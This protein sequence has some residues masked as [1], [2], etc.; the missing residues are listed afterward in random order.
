MQRHDGITN[1][2]ANPAPAENFKEEIMNL[3]YIEIDDRRYAIDLFNPID[4]ISW[5]S[6]ALAVF[7]SA[8]TK[9]DL[10]VANSDEATK[11]MTE[12]IKR[13]HT[14]KNEPLSDMVVFN[15]HFREHPGDLFQLGMHAMIRL[16]QD[17][18]PNHAS[19]AGTGSATT[20]MGRIQ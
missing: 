8:L 10:S 18:F 19:M 7:G 4:A 13:C 9:G 14:P 6:R 15:S 12:A 20:S 3:D 2:P 11:M 17:F 16:V 1:P 5:G